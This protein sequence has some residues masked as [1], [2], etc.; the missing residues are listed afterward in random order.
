T[1]ASGYYELINLKDGKWKL[2]IKAKGYKKGKEKVEIL[3]GGNHKKN[4]RELMAIQ[5]F[6]SAVGLGGEGGR[7]GEKCQPENEN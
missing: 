2:T 1:N 3:D 7:V 6:G 4:V 5:T